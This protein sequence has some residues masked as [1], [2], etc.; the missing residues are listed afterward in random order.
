M[1]WD[2]P[3]VRS[4]TEMPVLGNACTGG[5]RGRVLH[6]RAGAAQCRQRDLLEQT[7]LRHPAE[8]LVRIWERRRQVDLPRDPAH[9][10]VAVIATRTELSVEQIGAG[11]R[12]RA[13]VRAAAAGTKV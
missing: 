9:R 2:N 6:E 11:Q 4:G 8:I 7:S 1:T 10:L 12:R 13:L 5:H 3:K